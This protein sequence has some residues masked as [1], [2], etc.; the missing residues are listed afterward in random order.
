MTSL[1]QV[2]KGHSHKSLVDVIWKYVI[3]G[4]FIANMGPGED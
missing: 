4:I 2:T 3:Q 1:Q